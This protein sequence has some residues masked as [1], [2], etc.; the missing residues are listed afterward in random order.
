MAS[1]P[2]NVEGA[3]VIGF[4]AHV[5]TATDFTGTDV[6]PQRVEYAGGAIVLNEEKNIVLSPDEYPELKR[7]I[8]HTLIT[9]DGTT[10]RKSVVEGKRVGDGGGRSHQEDKSTNIE[11]A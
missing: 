7:Y 8:G 6:N 2:A 9:T 5:D 10:D 3:P 4:L 1:L 11:S